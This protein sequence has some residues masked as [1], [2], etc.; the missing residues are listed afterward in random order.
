MQAVCTVATT[1][2]SR[3]ERVYPFKKNLLTGLRM[4]KGIGQSSHLFHHS[5]SQVEVNGGKS[6]DLSNCP[7]IFMRWKEQYFVNV[8]TDSGLTI[9]GFY[10]VCFSCSDGSINGFYYDPNSRHPV[11]TKLFWLKTRMF[12]KPVGFRLSICLLNSNGSSAG[13]SVPSSALLGNSLKKLTSKISHQKLFPKNFKV[14]A[15]YDESKQTLKDKWQ[16]LSYD[17]SDDQ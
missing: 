11:T 9:A 3:A 1:A 13:A 6:L 8:R 5:M 10:Y 16:G 2:D 15:E 12:N 7:Y 14:V 17:E 4:I